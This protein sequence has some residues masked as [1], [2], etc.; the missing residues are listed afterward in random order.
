MVDAYDLFAIQASVYN[1][2]PNT[3]SE[4]SGVRGSGK[5]RQRARYQSLTAH[6]YSGTLNRSGTVVRQIP[7]SWLIGRLSQDKGYRAG[8]LR[9]EVNTMRQES[10]L[11]TIFLKYRKIVDNVL[12][13]RYLVGYV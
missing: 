5:Q 7:G 11:S 9:P 1:F 8:F 13:V 10:A 3:S 2:A 12:F 4:M 6:Q